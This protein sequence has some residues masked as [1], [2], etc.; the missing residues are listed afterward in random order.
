MT[1]PDGSPG[2]VTAIKAAHTAI[3]FAELSSI[4]WLVVTGLL[5]RRDRTTAVAAIAVGAQPAWASFRRLLRCSRP[6]A[7]AS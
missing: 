6:T 3:F 4:C 5:G 1:R 7:A 2:A